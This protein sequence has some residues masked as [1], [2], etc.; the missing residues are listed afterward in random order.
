MNRPTTIE[1]INPDGGAIESFTLLPDGR[2]ALVLL[3][4]ATL[5]LL[6]L[7]DGRVVW[8]SGADELYPAE[9][10]PPAPLGPDR[11]VV[12]G[13]EGPDPEFELPAAPFV[14]DLASGERLGPAVPSPPSVCKIAAHP[15]GRRLFVG[16]R[17][18][19]VALWDLATRQQCGG[20]RAHRAPI[21]HLCVTPDG[22]RLV[23]NADDEALVC[24]DLESS[25]CLGYHS[26]GGGEYV[27]VGDGEVLTIPYQ[28]I[29]SGLALA[30]SGAWLTA[31]VG[32][33]SP[34]S[35]TLFSLPSLVPQTALPHTYAPAVFLPDG[36][37]LLQRRGRYMSTP[38]ADPRNGL[39]VW[40]PDHARPVADLPGPTHALFTAIAAHPDGR[41]VFTAAETIERWDL[42]SAELAELVGPDVVSAGHGA[43]RLLVTPDGARLIAVYRHRVDCIPLDA[44]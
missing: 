37:L 28:N 13:V 7:V 1:V 9:F 21:R 15:D 43:R 3:D 11:A 8:M 38:D 35:P 17:D 31:F 20:W 44:A 33:E 2:R 27:T 30:P 16:H 34:L 18:G 32:D 36:R 40:D 25:L 6:D 19:N 4:F 39:L 24:W 12:L 41:R 42:E 22:A 10:Q 26:P 14:V 23:T 5:A 29:V